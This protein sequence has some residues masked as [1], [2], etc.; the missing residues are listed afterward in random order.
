MK[1]QNAFRWSAEVPDGSPRT[2]EHA[3]TFRS[4]ADAQ[5][6]RPHVCFVS[7][8]IYPVLTR[9]T[10][11]EFA[12]G[13]EMQQAVLARM[14][15]ADGYTV[16]VLTADH[17]QADVVDCDGIEIH[18]LPATARRGVRGLRF[19]HPLCT[20]IVRGLDRIDPDV[21]YF[22][23]AGFRAASVAWYARTR[24]KRFV[25][26]CASDR[27]FQGRAV[28][29]LPR[30]DELMFRFA[31]R[32]ADGVLV[33]NVDQQRQLESRFGRESSL[34]PNCYAEEQA[35]SAAPGGTVLWVGT[36]KPV[37]RPELFIQLAN[38]HPAKRF[39]MIGGADLANDPGQIYFGRMREAASAV[40]NLD[41]VG[42]VPL[43]EVGSHFDRASIFVNTSDSEG[44]PN[45]FLQAWIRGIPTLSF[46]RP[47]VV[48]GETGTLVCSNIDDLANRLEA[49]SSDIAAWRSAS[50][51]CFEHFSRVHSVDAA[52]G[53]Y[54]SFFQQVMAGARH[55]PQG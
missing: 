34:V 30:R 36:F 20:D 54:R 53:H 41:F 3:S 26:A 35:T 21:V 22:R 23:V 45:T 32:R 47:E 37:K 40:P 44:F 15:R 9:S 31:L 5:V 12:G 52:L 1:A 48:P 14:L 11:I 46:V 6:V 7:M 4:S 2:P 33:Q 51:A 25:Y 29:K 55:R 28:S 49:L 13:G 19:I 43:P 39:V 50:E 27:E 16:S 42:Y 38:R 17:G 10:E 18:R 24:R 8:N